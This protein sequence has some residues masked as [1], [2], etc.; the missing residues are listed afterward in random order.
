MNPVKLACFSAAY[1]AGLLASVTAHP[2]TYLYGPASVEHVADRMLAAIGKSPMMVNYDGEGFR[3]AC[4]ALNI[5]YSR[6]AI[7]DYLEWVKP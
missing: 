5:R 2:D 6:K 1:R 4:K 7:L 3:A